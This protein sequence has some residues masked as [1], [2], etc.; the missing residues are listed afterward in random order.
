M[1]RSKPD[2]IDIDTIKYQ[3]EQ[4]ELK[5]PQ[6]QRDFVWSIDAS[7]KLMDSIVKGYPIGA[8]TFWK[9]KDRLRSVK[10]IGGLTLPDSP[11]NDFV[12]YVLD[13]QQR[14]T[15][16][17]ACIKGVT[18]GNADYSK[19]YIDLTATEDDSIVILDVEGR[20]KIEYISLQNL[21]TGGLTFL[22]SVY[23]G[24]ESAIKKIEEYKERINKYS[25]SVIELQDAPLDIATEI[26]TR[27]NTTGKSLSLFEI[28]CAKTYDE[29][30]NFDLFEK[31]KIQLEKWENVSY[32]TVPHQTVLQAMS[33]CLQKSC[34]RKDILNIS[35][36]DFINAWNDVDLAFDSAIDYAKSFYG[37][38]VSKL[39]PYD[40]LLVPLVYYFYHHKKRPEGESAAR[41]QD[42]FWR[43]VISKRFTE[44]MEAKLATDCVNVIDAILSNNAPD[45]K[46]VEPID[47]SCDSI[48]KNG[49]FSL[50]SAYVK[51]MICIL[52][53]QHPKSFADGSTVVI[54]NAWLSQSN[55]KNYHHFFPKAYMKKNQNLISEDH[56]NHI[57]NITIVDGY[58]NKGIIKDKA[59]ADYMKKFKEDNKNLEATMETHLIDINDSGIW[60]NNY[61]IFFEKRIEQLQ[62]QLKKRIIV[63]TDDIID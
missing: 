63:R 25:F 58:L 22:M 31:R 29:E 32:D 55:S 16:I 14:I 13:G 4:G 10:N 49:T 3:I 50:S 11:K 5:V 60:E 42:Y 28:M 12:N 27:I 54:D 9:T 40:A 37:I 19:M 52:A 43:C 45:D 56:V 33:L 35:K 6:F 15:S 1:L 26:F 30:H 47:I 39:L 2:R 48:K 57:A 53:A 8:F 24:N 18:I 62:A 7:A 21:L 61:N 36:S 38:P 51:G 46:N 23:S 41:L 59:P 20:A 44:G 34:K 17:Y